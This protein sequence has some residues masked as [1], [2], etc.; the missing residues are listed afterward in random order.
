M[1]AFKSLVLKLLHLSPRWIC[2]HE[3]DKQSFLLFNERPVEL[4]F[5]FRHL[6]KICPR[7]ILDVGTGTTALPHLMRNCGPLV[8][9][10][11]NIRDYWVSGMYN[12]HYY[13][14][15][16]DITN[17]QINDTFD[18]ITCISVLEH[19]SDHYAAIRNMFRLLKPSGFLIL[20]FP[21]TEDRY[22]ENVYKLP[23]STYGQDLPF[24]TQSF[25]RDELSKWIEDN[26]G[27]IVDQEYWQFW[28]GNAWTVGNQIIPPRKVDV[29]DSHQISCIL[30]QKNPDA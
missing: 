10:I 19:I 20:T 25:S 14:I 3:F 21:Y 18:L 5:V 24:I 28:D 29:E 4:G 15:D 1:K 6:A 9:A 16:D 8:T 12:R 13:V 17:S 27:V 7:K 22:I 11:D 26:D 30:I 23:G 2:K